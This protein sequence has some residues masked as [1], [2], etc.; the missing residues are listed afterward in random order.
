VE[1]VQLLIAP[2][3]NPDRDPLWVL[4]LRGRLTL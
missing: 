3:L 4:G 1:P 2:V